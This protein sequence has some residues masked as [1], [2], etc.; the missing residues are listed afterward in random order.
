MKDSPYSRL[1]LKEQNREELHGLLIQLK[2]ELFDFR[3]MQSTSQLKDATKIK[4]TRRN[5]ARVLTE[6]GSRRNTQE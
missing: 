4:N 6:I 2:R 1:N 3:I 5:V